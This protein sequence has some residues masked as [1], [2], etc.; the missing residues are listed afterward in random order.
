MSRKTRTRTLMEG[1]KWLYFEELVKFHSLVQMYKIINFE[2]PT[3]LW[4]KLTIE[5]DKRIKIQPGRLRIS[6][7]SFRWRTSR[8]WNELPDDLLEVNKL[9]VFKK[10][11]KRYIIDMRPDVV[12]RRPPD[13]D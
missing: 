11:L 8:E 10:T 4:K 9:S 13:L 5:Q 1:C 12:Q 6:R 7:D 3:H 2:K